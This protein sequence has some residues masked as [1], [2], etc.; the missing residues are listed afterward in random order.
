M[1]K[2][3]PNVVKEKVMKVQEVQKIPIKMNQKRLPPRHITIK[4]AKFKNKERFLK[5]AREKELVTYKEA[6][7]RLS[8]DLSKETLQARM[9]WQKFSKK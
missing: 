7:I 5:A 3:F 2:N 6:P 9:D 4:M 1:T 8:A